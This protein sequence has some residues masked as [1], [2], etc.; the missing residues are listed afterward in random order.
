MKM[1]PELW[2]CFFKVRRHT[3]LRVLIIAFNIL[4]G[5][6]SRQIR[7]RKAKVSQNRTIIIATIFIL[8]LVPIFSASCGKLQAKASISGTVLMDG[9]PVSGSVL[10]KNEGGGAVKM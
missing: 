9:R 3:G 6:I 5:I 2:R 8:L 7:N 10:L 4:H 1:P